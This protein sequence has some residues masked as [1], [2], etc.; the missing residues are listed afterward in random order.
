M[1]SITARDIVRRLPG[2]DD[3][4]IREELGGNLCRCTGY[5]G[6]V[7]AIRAVLAAPPDD[8]EAWPRASLDP[9]PARRET[10]PR[11]RPAEPAHQAVPGTA[12][13]AQGQVK[14]STKTAKKSRFRKR[15]PA[16]R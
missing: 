4:R 8:S 14:R 7:A 15:F 6:I 9:P 10:L 3:A 11:A 2:A 12:R 16:R 13:A 1:I 5:V